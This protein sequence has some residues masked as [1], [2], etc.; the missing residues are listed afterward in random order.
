MAL[1]VTLPLTSVF[2]ARFE[3]GDMVTIT[4]Q[5]L[6]PQNLYLAGGQVTFSSTAQKD[7][8]VA[9]GKV[10]QNGP[11]WGDVLAAG[12]TVDIVEDV[13]GDIRVAGGQVTIQGMVGGD[14]TV[15]GGAVTILPGTVI[16]GDLVAAGGAVFMQGTVNGQTKLYA[17]EAEVNGTLAGPVFITSQE[18]ITF[19]E[20]TIIGSTLSYRSS[21]EAIIL[22][23]A[24]L[25]EKVTYTKLDVPKVD[26]ATFAAALLAVITV[27]VVVKFVALLVAALVAGAVWK[28]FSHS[29]AQNAV[30]KFGTMA[31]LG[32]GVAVLTPIAA[33]ALMVSVVGLFAGVL[34]FAAY[35]VALILAAIYTN[36]LAGA[37]VAKVIKKEVRIGWK[38]IVLGSVVLVV[39]SLIPLLGWILA[40]I[41]FLVSLGAVSRELYLTI[42]KWR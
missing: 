12:G 10:L 38:W 21:E 14:V 25:G 39:V 28:T 2:A 36:I 40:A 15:V 24:R 9:G 26:G 16:A 32:L 17:G 33:I 23:G 31:L 30:G 6:V 18:K 20:K 27:L 1:L 19:G 22:E 7:L 41:I 37:L 34:L 35:G 13:R 4:E 3:R 11:V 5:E 8:I 29:F 42:S